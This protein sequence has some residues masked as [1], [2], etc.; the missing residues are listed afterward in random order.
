LAKLVE[1]LN[2]GIDRAA[3]V[4]VQESGY[5]SVS[6]QPFPKG[7][8]GYNPSLANLYP[9]NPAKAKA[10]AAQVNGG[11][12]VDVTLTSVSGGIDDALAEQIQS[13]LK[14]DGIDV[15][16]TDIPAANETTFL[17]VNKSIAWGIDGT[18]GRE[19]PLQ[20]LDVLYDQS[21]L[22]DVDG[23]T[24]KEP[25]A[26]AAAFDKVYGI[27]LTSPKY[28]AALQ[29]AVKTAVTTDPIHIWLYYSPRIFAYSPKVTGIPSDLVQQRWEGVR[30]SS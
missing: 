11:K 3:L 21:G 26:V 7:Y 9:Y 20:M 29:S 16:I 25:V 27:P 12:P 30:V 17:Y 13:E 24:G 2:Y 22:M 19:S 5:G 4:Q 14:P 28:P 15:S 1:A 6:Y 18:A 23:K 8:V 10:L